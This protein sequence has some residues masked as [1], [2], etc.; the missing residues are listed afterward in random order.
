MQLLG[1]I[2]PHFLSKLAL[3]GE[4]VKD[5]PLEV[6][7]DLESVP[8]VIKPPLTWMAHKCATLWTQPKKYV[9][10]TTGSSIE[11]DHADT[12]YAVLFLCLDEPGRCG[13]PV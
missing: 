13:R 7:P 5:L 4:E 9:I 10:E 11:K 12:K 6:L 3:A 2:A 8:E 1:K